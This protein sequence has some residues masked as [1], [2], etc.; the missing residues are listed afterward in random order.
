MLIRALVVWFGLLALAIANGALRELAIV[1]STGDTAGHA[2]SSVTLSLAIVALSWFTIA[3]IAPR[4]TRDAWMIGALW[5]VLTLGFEFLAGHYLFGN[6]WNQLRADYDV[7]R[8]RI[9][10]LVLLATFVAPVLARAHI[11]SVR[12]L[13]Q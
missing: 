7:L 4:S 10:I 3:W 8:G 5:L 9:W 2:I 13:P 12:Q 1:P 11:I 6:P